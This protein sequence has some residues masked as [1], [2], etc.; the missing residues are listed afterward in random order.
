MRRSS[1]VQASDLVVTSEAFGLLRKA[2]IENLGT[3]KSGKLLLQFGKRLG[4][5]KALEL[6]NHHSDLAALIK[7]ATN[8]H[9]ELGH[10]SA[11][12]YPE[13]KPGIDGRI[14]FT[15]GVGIWK[16]SFEVTLH[17]NHFG[18]SEECS[19]YTLSG[20]ASGMM[21]TIFSEE[22]FVKEMTCRS[23]GDPD[24]SFDA[25]TRDDWESL[26]EDLEIYD[27][28]TFI[29]ELEATYDEL[30][31][32]R[33]LLNK[34]TA[35]HH[36]L[37]T[38]LTDG[39][40]IQE[41][42]N[43]AQ[44]I[45]RQTVILYHPSGSVAHHSESADQ[46]GPDL[47]GHLLS[48][49]KKAQI[50]RYNSFYYLVSPIYLQNKLHAFIAF[51]YETRDINEEDHLFIERLVSVLS[52]CMLNSQVAFEAAER[53]KISLLDQLIHEQWEQDEH[54]I[55]RLK[56]SQ[57]GIESHYT[58]VAIQYKRNPDEQI[59]RIELLMH[60][61]M[62][63]D[64]YR[65]KALITAKQD[66]LIVVG[67]S[68]DDPDTFR[69]SVAAV[70]D[71]YQNSYPGFTLTAG[72][73]TPFDDLTR[74]KPSLAQAVQAMNFPNGERFTHFN[75]LG[76]LGI[77]LEDSDPEKLL[78]LAR[79]QFNDLLDT[80]DDKNKEL[81]QTLYAYLK[82]GG[83]FEKIARELS[84]SVGGVQYR[85]RKIEETLDINLKDPSVT[86]YCLILLE[87]LI[88]MNQLSLS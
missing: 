71:Q 66:Y 22:I 7:E 51:Q 50:I 33:K 26:G 16:D 25:R 15:Q 9:I 49:V 5:N 34:V 53:L 28:T 80:R 83:R 52:L 88:L 54:F 20:F 68:I 10:I 72:F 48:A 82:H 69:K 73:S 75:D 70:M 62:L 4:E 65:L 37:T 13:I 64:K 61:A 18:Q 29:D 8:A 38:A 19:C 87:S 24:C 44:G 2:L 84:L 85:M 27:S 74:I 55:S 47:P 56:Y 30:F 23:K 3:E 43:I 32:H 81:L 67:Y 58:T 77:L 40:G 45:L 35:Y 59:D 46:S 42:V 79:K 17:L 86:S 76:F 14:E 21:S 60:F 41:I 63:I 12:L 6:K 31:E 78:H 39:K 11:V 36:Q 1:T 57:P